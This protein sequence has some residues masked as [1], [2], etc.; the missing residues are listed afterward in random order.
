MVGLAVASIEGCWRGKHALDDALGSLN[1][2]TL[3]E[4]LESWFV[5]IQHL[6]PS[7]TGLG[8]LS[9]HRQVSDNP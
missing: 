8:R 2:A 6:P 5:S 9:A 4:I 1:E 3:A 7:L